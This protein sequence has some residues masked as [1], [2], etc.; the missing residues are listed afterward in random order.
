MDTGRAIRSAA[1]VRLAFSMILFISP[2][3]LAMLVG[4]CRS[5]FTNCSMAG[6]SGPEPGGPE[7]DNVMRKL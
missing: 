3:E 1:A 6:K 2:L 7:P 5:N 4:V